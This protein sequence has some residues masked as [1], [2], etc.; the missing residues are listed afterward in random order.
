MQTNVI[1]TICVRTNNFETGLLLISEIFYF[2]V[3]ARWDM[4]CN[5]SIFVV[6][7]TNGILK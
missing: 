7:E 1:E 4:N 5:K 2:A 6:V 3:K